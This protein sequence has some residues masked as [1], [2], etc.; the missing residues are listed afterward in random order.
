MRWQTMGMFLKMGLATVGSASVG[1]A[2]VGASAPEWAIA[3]SQQ[4]AITSEF[5]SPSAR[6]SEI[7][8]ARPLEI[9]AE[10]ILAQAT[11]QPSP[12][13]APAP[14]PVPQDAYTRAMNIGYTYA[15][16]GD[17]HTALINF[18]R[19]LAERPGDRYALAA[20]RNMETYIAQQ[21]AAAARLQEIADLQVRLET[22]V[23]ALDWACAA[24]TVDQ[25]VTYFPNNS[26]EQARLVA[27]R[28]ELSGLLDA[29][30]NI[31]NWSIICPGSP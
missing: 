28:G 7:P 17:Y 29:R 30:A 12:S 25:L 31:E 9:P 3:A 24:A 14:K 16:L 19:A 11:T 2:M 18:R 4:L 21:R 13:A 6:S 22:A 27:Y 23:A 15:E 10:S 8:S 26:Y 1:L 20:I 5:V